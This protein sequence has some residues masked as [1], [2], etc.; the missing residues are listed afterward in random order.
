MKHLTFDEIVDF[1]S[2]ER[3]DDNSLNLASVVN[4]HICECQECFDIVKSLQ[5]IYEEFE[6]LGKAKDFVKYA[7][8]RYGNDISVKATKINLEQ[9][10]N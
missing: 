2:F 9:K 10:N 7:A 1:V 4:G 3:L 5:L 8:E 6:T